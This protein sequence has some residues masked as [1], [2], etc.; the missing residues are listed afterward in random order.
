[1]WDGWDVKNTKA[2]TTTALDWTGGVI[3]MEDKKKEYKW[4]VLVLQPQPHLIEE[5]VPDLQ[6]RILIHLKGF[7]ILPVMINNIKCAM[8]ADSGTTKCFAQYDAAA[9]LGLLSKVKTK[10]V[11]RLYLWN[12]EDM[13]LVVGV[14]DKVKVQLS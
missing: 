11:M 2:T 5:P 7:N 3:G 1:M 8:Y 14:I 10:Q 12:S 6:N 4:N 9:K 13:A